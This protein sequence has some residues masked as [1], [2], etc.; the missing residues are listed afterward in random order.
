MNVLLPEGALITPPLRLAACGRAGCAARSRWLRSSASAAGDD[1]LGSSAW[2]RGGRAGRPLVGLSDLTP[3]VW[4]GGQEI[5]RWRRATTSGRRRRVFSSTMRPPLQG[6]SEHPHLPHVAQGRGL[7]GD[8][9]RH[10]AG[11]G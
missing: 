3:V 1:E 8:E 10:A 11:S 9:T 2:R 7:R 4:P 5:E 6:P